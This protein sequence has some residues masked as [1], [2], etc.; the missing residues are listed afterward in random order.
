[1]PMDRDAHCE[2]EGARAAKKTGM[3]FQKNGLSNFC[4]AVFT[5]VVY[6]RLIRFGV[7]DERF[8]HAAVP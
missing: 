2:N 6:G 8:A 5:G 1:M 4:L 7:W 3:I